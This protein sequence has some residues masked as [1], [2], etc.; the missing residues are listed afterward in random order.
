LEYLDDAVQRIN[1]QVEDVLAY[2]R[3]DVGE[4]RQGDLGKT[5]ERAL[6]VLEFKI[7]K[8]GVTVIREYQA[9]DPILFDPDR[10]E[11]VA[12]NLILNALEAMPEGGTLTVKTRSLP[13]GV[14]VIFEDTGTGIDPAIRE[15]MFEPFESTKEQGTGL[16]L[17]I[18]H[19]IVRNHG[20]D[21]TVE[22]SPGKG[23]RF[24]IR[25]PSNG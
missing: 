9:A 23:S 12:L 18:V 8:N 6:S 11:Q 10:M 22:S 19:R 25:L 24:I 7:R 16:G 1:R 17:A 4:K 2:T 15:R 5:I 3:R 21:I 13:E 14:G 20:G